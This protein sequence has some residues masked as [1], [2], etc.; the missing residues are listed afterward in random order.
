MKS[1]P[2]CNSTYSDDSITFCLVDGSILSAPY[3]P[4]A[5]QRI[6]AARI[7]N[8]PAT[9]ILQDIDDSLT[10]IR[11]SIPLN[12]PVQSPTPQLAKVSPDQK[13][14]NFLKRLI[15]RAI[16]GI[17]IGA[18]TGLLVGLIGRLILFGRSQLADS[19][20]GGAIVGAILG[21][22]LIPI[23]VGLIKYAWKK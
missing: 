12:P 20:F 16:L 14:D 10:V 17:I 4:E 9:G 3:E 2:A 7:T 19:A 18:P 21:A 11:P 15:R 6:P 13:S 22:I 23:L 1:C 8:P 5:T